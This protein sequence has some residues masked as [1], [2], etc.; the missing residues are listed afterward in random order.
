[1]S[2]G[3]Q[4]A[5]GRQDQRALPEPRDGRVDEAYVALGREEPPA[6]LGRMIRQ[7]AVEAL[8]SEV[9]DDTGIRAM[10]A[11]PRPPWL[12][13]AAAAGV[14][15]LA[16]VAA[17]FLMREPAGESAASRT[18]PATMR[19]PAPADPAPGASAE[20]EIAS[21]EAGEPSSL[22]PVVLD[23]TAMEDLERVIPLIPDHA[24]EEDGGAASEGGPADIALQDVLRLYDSGEFSGAATALSGFRQRFPLHPVTEL[25]DAADSTAVIYE[26]DVALDDEVP[27]GS[28]LDVAVE[29]PPS[30]P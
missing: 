10:E 29:P 3:E 17:L 19:A 9:V 22:P 6:E 4:P 1:M 28:P 27:V 21:D 14:A 24:D 26:E 8:E 5:F 18:P 11:P 2:T 13:P 30:G 15:V 20:D 23:A 16:I 7:M 25:L 12:I